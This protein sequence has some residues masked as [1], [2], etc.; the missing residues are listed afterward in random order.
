MNYYI[1]KFKTYFFLF[2][3]FLFQGLSGQAI[4]QNDSVTANKTTIQ[5]DSS[6][7]EVEAV[8]VNKI[9]DYRNSNAFKYETSKMPGIDFWSIFWYWV[10]KILAEIFSS[11]GPAP[12]IRIVITVLVLAFVV[13]K[14]FGGN[15]SR[16]FSFNKKIKQKNRFEYSYD[17]IHQLDLDMKLNQAIDD[18]DY[19]AAI[20]YYYI[21]LLKELDFRHLI[22]WEAGKTNHDYQRE[23]RKD[24]LFESF[25]GLSGI[26][27]Y[28][29]YGNF[30]L[31]ESGFIKWESAFLDILNDMDKK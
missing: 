22:K 25:T 2:L 20:R 14:L 7:N 30:E 15:F 31:D 28:S 27:E 3:I 23:L 18:K 12:I 19:R 4:A 9:N 16:I 10:N 24:R 29:W 17:D 26:F 6:N 5:K 8:P 13:Y 21:K 1:I 11:E